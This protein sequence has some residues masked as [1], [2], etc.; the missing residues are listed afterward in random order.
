MLRM[1]LMT[2]VSVINQYRT[3]YEVDT[4]SL[5][6]LTDKLEA[7][8]SVNFR[9]C[10][11]VLRI[12]RSP[13]RLVK[14]E[15]KRTF[16]SVLLPADKHN[17]YILRG[18]A[19]QTEAGW[20]LKSNV[21]SHTCSEFRLRPEVNYNIYHPGTELLVTPKAVLDLHHGEK[22]LSCNDGGR[23]RFLKQDVVREEHFVNQII[24]ALWTSPKTPTTYV[25]GVTDL[26]EILDTAGLKGTPLELTEPTLL[27]KGYLPD[28]LKE[29]FDVN[30]VV[31]W[32]SIRSHQDNL[33]WHG[34]ASTPYV[35]KD[36]DDYF[37]VLNKLSRIITATMN[38]VSK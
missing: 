17:R 10:Y 31:R 13:V 34:D 26:R 37:N 22:T 38:G 4:E 1:E 29:Y 15:K 5:K 35:A 12:K 2:N 16:F 33:K 21:V 3:H 30:L 32:M 14:P 23:V 11:G 6:Q 18:E 19:L 9:D 24:S 36:C 25:T 28:I 7:G 27:R 20:L 8:V